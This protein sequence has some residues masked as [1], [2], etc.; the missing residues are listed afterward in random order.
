MRRG[1]DTQLVD[2]ETDGDLRGIV[3]LDDNVGYTPVALPL[4]FAWSQQG[5]VRIDQ[6]MI[7]GFSV[8]SDGKRVVDIRLRAGRATFENGAQVIERRCPRVCH[9]IP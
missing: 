1:A 4:L 9:F 2:A 3:S 5:L 8:C 7:D 6:R